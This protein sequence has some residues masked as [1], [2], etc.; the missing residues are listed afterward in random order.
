MDVLS[1]DHTSS[2]MNAQTDRMVLKLEAWS[3]LYIIVNLNWH[4]SNDKHQNVF[5]IRFDFDHVA[6]Q[7]ERFYDTFMQHRVDSCTLQSP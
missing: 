1:E 3:P 5:D 2:E 6:R 7:Q 4:T